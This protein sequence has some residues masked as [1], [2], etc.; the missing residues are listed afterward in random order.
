VGDGIHDDSGMAWLKNHGFCEKPP[1]D[2]L[3]WL[4]NQPWIFSLKNPMDLEWS[5]HTTYHLVI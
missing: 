1:R 4:F 3:G 2:G 5:F